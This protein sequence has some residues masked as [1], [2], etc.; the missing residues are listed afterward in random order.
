[1]QSV[2]SGWLWFQHISKVRGTGRALKCQEKNNWLF[3]PWISGF[4][5]ALLSSTRPTF[6]SK[7]ICYPPP[8]TQPW[9][10]YLHHPS[11]RFSYTPG[12]ASLL[13]PL[14]NTHPIFPPPL[15][16]SRAP[17]HT[18]IEQLPKAERTNS[19]NSLVLGPCL[20]WSRKELFWKQ[21]NAAFTTLGHV[22]SHFG[23]KIFQKQAPAKCQD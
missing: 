1:M 17:L 23:L 9:H 16:T 10:F 4:S 7:A 15:L 11:P 22:L 20:T 14:P 6:I 21:S 18:R 3:F 12:T 8:F 2:F 13:H 5:N 19:Y